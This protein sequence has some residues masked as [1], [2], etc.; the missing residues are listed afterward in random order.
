MAVAA[1]AVILVAGYARRWISDDGLIY[2]RAVE[3]ILAGNGPVYNVG[4]RAETSTGTL[5]QWL[6]TVVGFVLPDSLPQLAVYLGLAFTGAAFALGVTGA[7][8]LHG[9][10]PVPVGVVILLALSP[11]WDF[12]TSG[13]ETG[14]AFAW[15]AGGWWMLVHSRDS[16]RMSLSGIAFVLG[17]GPLVRPDLALVSIVF[18]IAL[19]LL[20]RPSR[21]TTVGMLAVA[22][23][24]PVAYQV[25]RMGYY[26][27]L[28]PLPAISKEASGSHWLRGFSYFF[29]L[30]LTY[31]ALIP[32][33]IVLWVGLRRHFNRG[34]RILVFAPVIAGAL[35]MLYVIKVGGDFMH[36]RMLLPGLLLLMLPFF[37][38]PRP[39][40]PELMKWANAALIG[41]ALLA[42]GLLRP[43]YAPFFGPMGVADE[44]SHYVHANHVANPISKRDYVEAQE[45][46]RGWVRTAQG[47]LVF[48][49]EKPRMEPLSPRR[50]ERVALVWP[51]LGTAGALTTLDETVVDPIGLSYPL[52]AHLELTDRGGRVGHEKK[53]P[54]V[55]ITAD[56]GMP[57]KENEAARRALSCGAL[58]ELQESVRAPMTWER[59]VDN[60]LGSFSRTALRVPA[61]PVAAERLFCGG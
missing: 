6:L 21:K 3:Q 24:L 54:R 34:D 31:G 35:S 46:K 19:W 38:M 1:V 11:M 30:F 16:S 29:D 44:R 59:F 40:N 52:A 33:G 23:A 14:L 57:T 4:E 50:T 25:F 48:A 20:H 41:W 61:D 28:V 45:E 60:F 58:A 13:L 56:Y 22:G 43:I 7:Q 27:V 37:C 55:W 51:V 39:A 32:V 18:L 36:G 17:L 53:L 15:I 42:A 5:W 12:A 47:Q 26:G 8:R 9:G 2:V 10:A 49:L